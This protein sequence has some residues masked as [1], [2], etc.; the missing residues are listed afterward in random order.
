MEYVGSNDQHLPVT[1]QLGIISN[2]QQAAC[3][4]DASL[5][6]NN[7]P[8]PFYRV[9]AS[10]TALGASATIPRWELLR[11]YPLFNGVSEQR[12]PTESG[13]LQTVPA[14]V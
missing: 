7:V 13:R 14:A 4:Q 3:N 9:L 10:N 8:N 5:C 6:N 12:L 2:D 1:S 11:G